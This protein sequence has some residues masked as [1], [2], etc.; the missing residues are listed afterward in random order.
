MR[1]TIEYPGK[2]APILID[3]TR[4]APN[5]IIPFPRIKELCMHWRSKGYR[6][7]VD[8]G[9]GQLRNALVLAR[10]FRLWVCDFPEQFETPNVAQRLAS[11]HR[12]SNFL[13]VISP[14]EFR[15]GK[16]S[17]D[18]VVLAYV[19][20]TLPEPRLRATLVESAVRNTKAPHELFVAAPNAEYYYRQRM[21]SANGL[22]DGHFFY[23]GHG[24]A[25]FYR[26]YT[27]TELDEFMHTFGF[28][29]DKSFSV[30]KKNQR[31]YIKSSS[32]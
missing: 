9:C 6:E 12:L 26:E 23:V 14:A 13:G 10:H 29:A 17:A 25:T 20:H 3:L 24:R 15:T 28:K 2:E 31:I 22:N 19:L 27:A 32:K 7:V 16:V 5:Q 4:S 18:A 11:L 1:H 21:S 8:L 30:D